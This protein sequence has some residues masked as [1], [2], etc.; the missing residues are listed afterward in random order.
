MA[1]LAVD[2]RL[3]PLRGDARFGALVQRLGL[4]LGPS[5]ADS[6]RPDAAAQT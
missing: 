3:D 4:S 2:P 6:P 1:Y 5:A